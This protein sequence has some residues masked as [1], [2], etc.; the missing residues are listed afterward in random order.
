MDVDA[1]Y[2]P[3]DNTVISALDSVVQVGE[4]KKIPVYPAEGDSVAKGGLATYG[5]NY[6]DLGYQTGEMAIK[7]LVDGEDPATMAVETQKE[8]VIYLNLGAAERMG[9]EL[10]QDLIDRA[11][12][13]NITK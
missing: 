8:P 13:A 3:T 2:V 7:I 1:I 11:D 12:E 4:T 6:F 10:P 5:L 9:V